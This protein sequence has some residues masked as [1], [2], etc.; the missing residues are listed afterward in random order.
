M[1]SQGPEFADE[2]GHGDRSARLRGTPAALTGAPPAASLLPSRRHKHPQAVPPRPGARRVSSLAP[3]GARRRAAPHRKARRAGELSAS[4]CLASRV[5]RPPPETSRGPSQTIPIPPAMPP[6]HTAAFFATRS[7][8]LGPVG[9]AT[10]G[11]ST[12]QHQPL[13]GLLPF[14]QH[15]SGSSRCATAGP[16]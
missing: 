12:G 1:K 10:A 5:Y 8:A 15:A 7:A 11:P 14:L 9:G 13:H 4:H 3:A 16:C 6:R 2:A